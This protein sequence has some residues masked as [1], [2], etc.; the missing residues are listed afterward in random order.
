MTFQLRGLEPWVRG[1]A[2]FALNI[3]A[4]N[5][6]PV[7]VTSVRRTFAEQTVLRR[8]WEQGKSRFPANRPGESSHNFGLAF[9]SWVAERDRQAWEA[10]REW[11]G[12]RVPSNDWIHGEVPGWRQ[13]VR[14][15]PGKR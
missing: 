9:D 3:A 1:P 2:Q 4:A 8:K 12:F 13:F 15:I 5:R 11:V 7:T 6:I 10:I 14:R